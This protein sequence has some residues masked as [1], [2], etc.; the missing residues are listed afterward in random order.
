MGL[1]DALLAVVVI[2]IVCYLIIMMYRKS[3]LAPSVPGRREQPMPTS[4]FDDKMTDE[5]VK[6]FHRLVTSASPEDGGKP[7]A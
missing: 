2:S 1:L 4:S 3:S 5:Q 7:S 6:A